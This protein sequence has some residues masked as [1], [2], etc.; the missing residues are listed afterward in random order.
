MTKTEAAKLVTRLVG[1]F[2]Q[3]QFSEANAEAYESVLVTMDHESTAEAIFRL[4]TTSKWL[5]TIA[6]IR[7]AAVDIQLG[8][9]KS[10]VE[11]WAE[12]MEETGRVGYCGRPSFT[13]ETI[14]RVVQSMGWE[15]L[16][17]SQNLASDRARFCELYDT[18]A[19]RD[20]RDAQAGAQLPPA[21][22]RAE[23]PP[24]VRALLRG[25]GR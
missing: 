16:C 4:V 9:L 15:Q 5:P 10:G 23:L 21:G 18:W 11:A 13:D 17:L 24:K 19:T 22:S 8:P 1:F 6:E 25:V 14:R 20:R 12:V 3:S 2:P 7:A